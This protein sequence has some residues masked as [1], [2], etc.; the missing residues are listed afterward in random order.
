MKNGVN[1]DVYYFLLDWKDKNLIEYQNIKGDKR[2]C[3]LTPYELNLLYRAIE[4]D[5]IET[6]K[7]IMKKRC[8]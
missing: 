5:E 4:R 6:L 3:D 7:Q 1:D 2:L 8:K